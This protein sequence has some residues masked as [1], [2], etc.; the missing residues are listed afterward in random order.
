MNRKLLVII[1]V[2]FFACNDNYSKK[3]H[4]WTTELS[5]GLYIER[6]T[7]YG[8]GA[9]GTDKVSVYLTDSLFFNLYIGTFDEGNEYYQYSVSGDSIMVKKFIDDDIEPKDRKAIDERLFL[10]SKLKQ[11]NNFNK[12]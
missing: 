6:F 8:S 9:F 5:S 3:S 2:I 1:S 4:K 12:K 10:L 11:L 7:V